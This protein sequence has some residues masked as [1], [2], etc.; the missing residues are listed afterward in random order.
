MFLPEQSNIPG[1]VTYVSRAAGIPSSS[2]TQQYQGGECM[3]VPSELDAIDGGCAWRTA[4]KGVCASQLPRG[5]SVAVS[6]SAPFIHLTDWG[7]ATV[8][9]REISDNAAEVPAARSIGNREGVDGSLTSSVFP[10]GDV[11][12]TID[13]PIS[14]V[15]SALPN[16]EKNNME[17]QDDCLAHVFSRPESP[18]KDFSAESED[19]FT[20]MQ[21]RSVTC[22]PNIW[23]VEGKDVQS[24]L[25]HDAVKVGMSQITPSLFSPIT[26]A[27]E[28]AIDKVKVAP[29]GLNDCRTVGPQQ[30]TE[31]QRI[32]VVDPQRSKLHVP[33]SSIIPTKALGGRVSFPS[34]CLLFQSGRCL[35]GAS[36]YQMHIDPQV[37]QRLRQINESLPYCC[38]FHG[39]CNANKWDA[40]ANAHRT[41]LIKGAAV[42][43]SRVAYTNGLERF[44]LK[45]NASRSLNTCAV[46]R[47][48]G[49]PGGCRYGADCWYVHIC[50]DVL[51]ELVATIKLDLEDPGSEDQCKVPTK[52]E[53]TGNR[54]VSG[55]L[56]G[57]LSQQQNRRKQQ[58]YPTVAFHPSKS[59]TM[60]H[61]HKG[62][63]IV[64]SERDG[65]H[66]GKLS[67]HGSASTNTFSARASPTVGQ[68]T[69]DGTTCRNVLVQQRPPVYEDGPLGETRHG[70]AT[71]MRLH[72]VAFPVTDPSEE[73]S[74][75]S[76]SQFS[77]NDRQS[78]TPISGREVST[79]SV[80]CCAMYFPQ[81]QSSV[82]PCPQ[83]MQ[84][85]HTVWPSTVLVPS[86]TVM[87]PM[88]SATG[89]PVASAQQQM[90]TD[91]QTYGPFCFV[92]GREDG[93][94]N[95][96]L[97]MY[98]SG[99]GNM[100]SQV[101]LH[102]PF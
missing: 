16:Q 93:F 90:G 50:R 23:E 62:R 63:S 33:L 95:L 84:N 56:L 13:L 2:T 81:K 66:S 74:V 26:E 45:N 87:Y 98:G 25:I 75:P 51:K 97:P 96:C 30:P 27:M 79:P 11:N 4:S 64:S 22:N 28:S 21:T 46:C 34:L 38:A 31:E 89:L 35:R 82:A 49:K 102:V 59:P 69:S 20:I 8:S 83:P 7:D 52:T 36:C 18:F 58:N 80:P 9:T 72:G 29:D 43:L 94:R 53:S 42:P 6:V 73:K 10:S 68:I 17:F 57:A 1:S 55:D 12:S 88:I 101:P 32:P 85:G 100:P 86:T 60:S 61:L 3:G 76:P 77:L 70:L 99:K 41:I 39:E 78:V 67:S 14:L 5:G 37:V 92:S 15:N 47:L 48:H 71:T 91:G 65:T 19:P 24:S 44:V 40:E 54:V